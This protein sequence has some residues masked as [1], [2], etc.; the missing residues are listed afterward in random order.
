MDIVSVFLS[1]VSVFGFILA[2]GLI[3]TCYWRYSFYIASV[4]PFKRD[5][6]AETL[7]TTRLYRDSE[8]EYGFDCDSDEC[9]DRSELQGNVSTAV[10]NLFFRNMCD[11]KISLLWSKFC[12]DVWRRRFDHALKNVRWKYST[13]DL[14]AKHHV[15]INCIHLKNK[16][17][18]RATENT[19][20][21]EPW[22]SD[23]SNGGLSEKQNT[24]EHVDA[25]TP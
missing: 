22:T 7:V 10:W 14:V 1:Y 25:L 2:I 21:D 8:E 12:N 19:N 23:K 11:L 13:S 5:P 15:N 17:V 24:L 3:L 18:A 20:H 16:K 6:L 9:W 4:N